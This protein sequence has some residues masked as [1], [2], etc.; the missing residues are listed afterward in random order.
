MEQN[1]FKRFK[2]LKYI[3]LAFAVLFFAVYFLLLFLTPS[4]RTNIF[5]NKS[6]LMICALLWIFMLY[7][8]LMLLFDF[9]RIELSI[10]SEHDLNRKA[11]LDTLTGIPNRYSCDLIFDTYKNATNISE[12]GCVLI[13]ISNLVEINETQG[14]DAGDQLLHDFSALL[15]KV[16]D[17]YGFVGRNGGNEFIVVLENCTEGY[18]A[19]FLSAVEEEIKSC[20]MPVTIA[21][22]YVLNHYEQLEHFMDLVSLVYKKLLK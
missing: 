15:E 3:Q 2:I 12:I 21:S 13:S 20:A 16:A 14:H 7:T 4:L 6:L 22:A 17:C 18:V 9:R 5:T 1:S 8:F 11:Y 10:A 19:Q